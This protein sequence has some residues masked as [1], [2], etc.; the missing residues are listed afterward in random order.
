MGGGDG[1]FHDS[2]FLLLSVLKRWLVLFGFAV[3]VF[4]AALLGFA[5][6]GGGGVTLR[7]FRGMKESMSIS[8]SSLLDM[9]AESELVTAGTPFLMILLLEL[10]E[11]N[12][13]AL[14][15]VER[16]ENDALTF[17]GGCEETGCC[18]FGG[19][20]LVDFMGEGNSTACSRLIFVGVD[21]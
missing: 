3:L 12:G 17:F 15:S 10:C 11:L 5:A 18:A 21:S 6:A 14:D 1:G 2:R 16:D 19:G 13:G 9:L 20:G 7:F 8:S 4:S